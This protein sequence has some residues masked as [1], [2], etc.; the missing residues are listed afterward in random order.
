M[1]LPENESPMVA[2]VTEKEKV[3]DQPFF[4]RAEDGDVLLA[5][6]KSMKAI[7][8]RPSEHKIIEVAPIVLNGEQGSM[9]QAAG[10]EVSPVSVSDVSTNDTV[11][12]PSYE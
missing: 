8:Y 3:N 4:T 5:Y 6:T 9:Q 11:S 12:E 10:P 1:V 7:L 2:T